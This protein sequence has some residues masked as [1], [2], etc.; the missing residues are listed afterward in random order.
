MASTPG[1]NSLW[2]PATDLRALG[3]AEDSNLPISRL[4]NDCRELGGSRCTLVW[5]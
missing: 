4:G 3:V 1:R 5:K 2:S